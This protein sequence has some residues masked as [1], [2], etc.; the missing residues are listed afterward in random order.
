MD[1]PLA[2]A[3]ETEILPQQ[4]NKSYQN[5]SSAAAGC[6]VYLSESHRDLAVLD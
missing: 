3:M 1:V 4:R 5:P 6:R 2:V